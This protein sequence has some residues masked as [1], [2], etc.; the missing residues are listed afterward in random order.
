MSVPTEG[1]CYARLM[2]HIIRCEEESAML[3]H[4]CNANDHRSKALQWL[5][6]SEFFRQMQVKLTSIAMGRMQ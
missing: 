6:V 1:E 2:E 5:N 3:A 4:L